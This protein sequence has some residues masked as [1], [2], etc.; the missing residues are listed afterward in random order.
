M[1]IMDGYEPK[2]NLNDNLPVEDQAV[3]HKFLASIDMLPEPEEIETD[4][5]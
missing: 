4:G 3:L 2:P 5:S 1:G